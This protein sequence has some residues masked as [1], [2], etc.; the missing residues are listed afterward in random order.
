ME[1]P[2][3]WT[4]CPR[5]GLGKKEGPKRS[6][7]GGGA[8]SPAQYWSQVAGPLS[9]K[10]LGWGCRRPGSSRAAAALEVQAVAGPNGQGQ[11]GHQGFATNLY[12]SLRPRQAGRHGSGSIRLLGGSQSPRRR[13][14]RRPSLAVPELPRSRAVAPSRKGDIQGLEAGASYCPIRRN[15]VPKAKLQWNFFTP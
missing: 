2:C 7:R 10:G 13:S 15:G 5:W 1:E 11:A 8:V 12:T 3:S 6:R 4:K 9:R 14:F